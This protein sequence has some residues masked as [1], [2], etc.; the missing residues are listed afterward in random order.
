MAM[1]AEVG[2]LRHIWTVPVMLVGS[3]RYPLTTPIGLRRATFL[4]RPAR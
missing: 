4:A 2:R 3:P 1:T